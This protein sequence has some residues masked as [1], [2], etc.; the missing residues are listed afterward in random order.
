MLKSHAICIA[1]YGREFF[2]TKLA[3]VWKSVGQNTGYH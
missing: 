3:T 2:K 1:K